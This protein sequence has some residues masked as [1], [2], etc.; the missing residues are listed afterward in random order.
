MVSDLSYSM[1]LE[2]EAK[3]M[4]KP[5][6]ITKLGLDCTEYIHDKKILVDVSPWSTYNY[7]IIFIFE[8]I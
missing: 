2:A 8:V 4:Q 3:I 5:S 6:I 7:R 1:C